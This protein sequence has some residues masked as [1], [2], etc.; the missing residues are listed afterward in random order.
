LYPPAK[1]YNGSFEAPEYFA[2]TCA[3][4]LTRMGLLRVALMLTKQL[5]QRSKVLLGWCTLAN[6]DT[7]LFKDHVW[8]LMRLLFVNIKSNGIPLIL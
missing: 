4:P 5:I 6:G 1:Q 2:T 3:E 7:G 8:W